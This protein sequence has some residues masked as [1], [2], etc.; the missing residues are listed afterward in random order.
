[1]NPPAAVSTQRMHPAAGLPRGARGVV[2]AID[3]SEEIV[4]RLASLGIVPGTSLRVVRG[5]S[6]M[7]IAVGDARLGLGRTWADAVRVVPL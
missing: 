7:A 5:G 3:G 4:A 1:M 2:S 6:P